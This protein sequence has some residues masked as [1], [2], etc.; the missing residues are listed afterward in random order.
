MSAKTTDRNRPQRKRYAE[1]LATLPPE[2][3]AV[4][5][6][7]LALWLREIVERRQKQEQAKLG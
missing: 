6:I 3:Q 2:R 1:L 4:H 5:A 7:A